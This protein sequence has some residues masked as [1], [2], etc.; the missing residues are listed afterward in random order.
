LTLTST[1]CSQLAGEAFDGLDTEQ[2]VEEMV[3][4]TSDFAAFFFTAYKL[5]LR[6]YSRQYVAGAELALAIG[7]SFLGKVPWQTIAMYAT[8][9][10]GLCFFSA[11]RITNT[12]QRKFIR[13][14]RS[15]KAA[16]KNWLQQGNPNIRHQFSLLEAEDLVSKKKYKE[17]QRHFENAIRDAIRSGFIH[18]AAIARERYGIFLN[19]IVGDLEGSALQ[20]DEALCLYS[21]WGADALLDGLHTIKRER[22]SC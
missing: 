15:S 19:D 12:N 9:H 20:F 4:T 13:G 7:P 6:G 5:I 8:F 18:D 10:T 21:E 11:A 1:S 3:N 17:A 22:A 2:A 14:G 16:L